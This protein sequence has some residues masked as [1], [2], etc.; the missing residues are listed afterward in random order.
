VIHINS[1][2]AALA[3]AL[4]IGPRL[5]FKRVTTEPHDT[6]YIVL[7]AAFLWFGWFGFNAGSAVIAGALTSSAF[8]VT[9]VATAT[10]ALSWMFM[11]WKFTG[12]PSIVGAASGAVAGLV[13]ITPA[14][15]FVNVIGALALGMA[16]GVFCFLAATFRARTRVDDTLDVWAVHGVGGTVGALGTGLFATKSVNPAGADGLFYGNPAQFGI[17]LIDVAAV[18]IY[19]FVVSFVILKLIDKVMGLRPTAA[20]E[21]LGLD[22]SQHGEKSYSEEVAPSPPLRGPA[23]EARVVV[24]AKELGEVLKRHKT[25]VVKVVDG[26]IVFE[27]E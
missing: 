1:G 26:K 22:L 9:H 7:G 4:V 16:A 18:W 19:S 5:G 6:T 17:Q 3:A 2:M 10:A 15:G 21:E 25:L 8:T 12:K 20:E 27:P 24:Q 11:S 13:A 14:S 23:P